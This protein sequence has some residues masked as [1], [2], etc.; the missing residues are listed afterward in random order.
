[1][2]LI[3]VLTSPVL[4]YEKKPILIDSG[5][6]SYFEKDEIYRLSKFHNSFLINDKNP[7]DK[8]VDQ[9]NITIVG[10]INSKTASVRLG[11]S[12]QH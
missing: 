2:A 9:N 12:I 8:L 10:S 5:R 7:L 3:Q 11:Q 1:M 6:Q 4:F